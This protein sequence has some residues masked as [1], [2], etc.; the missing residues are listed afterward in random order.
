MD[1]SWNTET[2]S[3]YLDNLSVPRSCC[4]RHGGNNCETIFHRGCHGILHRIA[5]EGILISGSLALIIGGGLV[6]VLSYFI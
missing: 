4:R 5:V 3:N 2:T 1:D 6:S